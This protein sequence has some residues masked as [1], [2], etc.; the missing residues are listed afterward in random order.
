MQLVTALMLL[1]AALFA[2]TGGVVGEQELDGPGGAASQPPATARP[3]APQPAPAAPQPV[4]EAA[5]AQPVP[6]KEA[7]PAEVPGPQKTQG[8]GS[9][10]PVA[11]FWVVLP[12]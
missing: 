12:D 9:D 10:K 5:P 2:Q 7:A 6:V 11:A 1:G 8:T 3:A 4:V